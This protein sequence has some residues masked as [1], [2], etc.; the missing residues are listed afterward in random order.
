MCLSIYILHLGH[1]ADAFIQSD[2]QSYIC[3]KKQQYISVGTDWMFIEPGSFLCP[4]A[5]TVH[6]GQ[7]PRQHSRK[8]PRQHSREHPRQHSREHPRQHPSLI[9]IG[10]RLAGKRPSEAA[11]SHWD[12]AGRPRPHGIRCL[13]PRPPRRVVL[14]TG[15]GRGSGDGTHQAVARWLRRGAP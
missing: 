14:V 1:L 11:A 2:L 8:H 5:Y 4:Q 9:C 15:D 10:Q 13:W 6:D 7:H 12:T 3:Q